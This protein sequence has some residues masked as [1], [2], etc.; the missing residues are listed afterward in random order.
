MGKGV[1][2]V[3][4]WELEMGLPV[5]RPGRERHIV[6]A[7]IADLDEWVKGDKRC[8]IEAAS[9]Q[10]LCDGPAIRPTEQRKQIADELRRLHWLIKKM[11]AALAQNREHATQFANA[12]QRLAKTSNGCN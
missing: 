6:V 9:P 10:E 4:R 7:Y 1:R 3:Q 12:V 11:E 5:R 8:R 2:T